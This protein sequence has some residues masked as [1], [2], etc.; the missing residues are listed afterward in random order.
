MKIGKSSL[1]FL[2]PTIIIFSCSKDDNNGITPIPERDRGEQ[3]IEDDAALQD[4]LSS[5]YYN[6]SDFESNPN[7]STSDLVITALPETGVLPNPDQNT[8]LLDAVE[9]YTVTFSDTEYKY[10]VLRLNQG[11]GE[12]SPH[13]CDQVRVIYEGFLPL[14]D[15]SVFDGTPT[16]VDFF[17]VGDGAST[18]GVIPGWRKVLPLFNMAESFINNG[19]GTTTY[20]NVGVGVMFI[21][22]GLGYFSNATGSIPS[23]APLGFKFDLLE[24]SVMDHDNDGVFSYLEDLNED[25]EFTV[26][27]EDANDDTDDDTDGDFR[28]NYFDT[29]DDG[30]GVLTINEDI[31]Q[32][33]D[34]TNDIGANGI[35]KY[36]DPLETESIN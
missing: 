13:F 27:F 34:P 5:Y 3:Q 35:P 8:L 26:N 9:E 11:G 24:T 16:P 17:L 25:G 22:S 6:A 23:Y 32:D 1:L 12:K 36:L 19:D 10:Y 2:I 33:G 4:Y 20:N 30:D 18:F 31:N 21:P 29:D 14:N 28:P 7:P 15:N